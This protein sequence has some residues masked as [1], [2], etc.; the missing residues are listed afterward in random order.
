MYAFKRDAA[1]EVV[2]AISISESPTKEVFTD[3][4]DIDIKMIAVIAGQKSV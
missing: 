3:D 2:S 4:N 1:D